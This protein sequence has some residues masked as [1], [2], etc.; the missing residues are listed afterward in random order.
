MSSK[1]KFLIFL[2]IIFIIFPVAVF[3]QTEVIYP[4]IPGIISP[5]EIASIAEAEEDVLPLFLTYL[6]QLILIVSIAVALIVVIYGG[7][8]YILS[9][10]DPEKKK[11]AKGWMFSALHGIFIIL[12]SFLILSLLDSRLVLFNLEKLE[13]RE[14]LG[15][16][17]LEWAMKNVFYQIPFGLLVEDAVLNENGRDKLYDILDALDDAE[18]TADTI[19][20]GSETMMACIESCPPPIPCDGPGD[21]CDCPCW[22]Y[23]PEPR[24]GR[25]D[26]DC[27]WDS[28]AARIEE[29]TRVVPP[30]ADYTLEDLEALYENRFFPFLILI[31]QLGGD[32]RFDS[33][34]STIKHGIDNTVKKLEHA[35]NE[36]F[37][38]QMR[39][40]DSK[41]KLKEDLTEVVI[42]LKTALFYQVM[43]I[44]FV[45][46][47]RRIA[48]E[49]LSL[50]EKYPELGEYPFR[51]V[52]DD[53]LASGDWSTGEEVLPKG[54]VG[55]MGVP[56]V[57]QGDHEWKH[58]R[59]GLN[60]MY[61]SACGL[62]TGAMVLQHFGVD[63]DIID[64][65]N[66]AIENGYAGL[67]GG[68]I[69]PFMAHF[70]KEHGLQA[71]T[72]DFPGAGHFNYM[73]DWLE[74]VGP[75]FIGGFNPPW[76][77]GGGHAIA[78]T[79]V[80]RSKGIF[81]LNDPGAV[82]FHTA[83][84]AEVRANMPIA[85]VYVWDEKAESKNADNVDLA[86]IF[87]NT[88]EEDLKMIL[89][90]SFNSSYLAQCGGGSSGGGPSPGGGGG[91][92]VSTNGGGGA[93]AP[94]PCAGC[95]ILPPCLIS[96]RGRL[97]YRWMLEHQN[98]LITLFFLKDL[99]KEDLYQLYK[100][101][102]LKSINTEHVINYPTLLL[103]K[104]LY[105]E[106]EEVVIITDDEHVKIERYNKKYAQYD[107]NC[108]GGSKDVWQ[109]NFEPM[110]SN[111]YIWNWER[112]LGD[113]THKKD[114]D[115]NI[116]IANDPLTFY[117]RMPESE[118]SIRDA[119]I[120]LSYRR[121]QGDIQYTEVELLQIDPTESSR[122]L[123]RFRAF[124]E[125]YFS[126]P[127]IIKEVSAST[128]MERL[129]NY[130]R[131]NDIDPRTISEKE[132]SE[133]LKRLGIDPEDV[134]VFNLRDIDLE[135][136]SDYLTCGM[137]IPVGETF[138]LVWD[139]FVELMVMI[140]NYVIEGFAMLAAQQKMNDLVCPITGPGPGPS[141]YSCCECPC[142]EGSDGGHCPGKCYLT[143]D[144]DAIRR[145]HQEVLE[146]RERMKNLAEYIVH[147]TEGFYYD[148]SENLCDPLNYDV[149]TDDE[150][151]YCDQF[152]S[153]N[154]NK[155]EATL[156]YCWPMQLA[157][158]L[159]RTKEIEEEKEKG[160]FITKHELITRK[161][162]LSRSM[163]DGCITRPEHFA[164]VEGGRRSGSAPIFGP[165]AEK[166]D[167]QRYT[168]TE[169]NGTFVNTHDFNWFCCADRTRGDPHVIE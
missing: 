166:Y 167:L 13:K 71:R 134:A 156:A 165:I 111:P 84:F 10:E 9:S 85:I 137:E 79:G 132:F 70:A 128:P 126:L 81:F 30:R 92:G 129:N 116:T 72:V 155:G 161:L 109:W 65:M 125:R 108:G 149:R 40:R 86:E 99:L 8:L 55:Y 104:M 153:V 27:W 115:C 21:P 147:L 34:M 154:D 49:I 11:N 122:P 32:T 152:Y 3:G 7:V 121:Q 22:E 6:F 136:A 50:I 151:I 157:E 93:A 162:N 2:L 91:V 66:F 164:D 73:V 168:K 95:R 37:P 1:L 87:Y 114:I 56:Y 89:S 15:R 24:R 140:D 52:F 68:V 127:R 45:R 83:T 77:M 53:F 90:N 61:H 145:A 131:E 143:C 62:A 117:L 105:R 57:E 78:I 124:R 74:N 160:I 146:Y 19:K 23:P 169:E 163:F 58:V 48:D 12:A 158:L 4:N 35:M 25:P 36:Y 18:Y 20:R 29:P 103:E 159:R 38:E 67:H 59:F 43:S 102:M 139:H 31:W 97:D 47:T 33:R 80:D 119:L 101:F 63:V 51:G 100:A 123:D 138:Q 135:K 141:A 5:Q 120:K 64:A 150:H 54:E 112:W 60:T 130:F 41:W 133:I 42:K 96:V 144:I 118:E 98:D 14:T 44:D 106:D 110:V 94:P 17:E 107:Y 88:E 28:N 148:P 16:I 142:D 82:Y 46:A 39:V 26:L 113:I 76:S 75:I 69:T